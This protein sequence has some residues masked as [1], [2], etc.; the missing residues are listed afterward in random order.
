[1]VG[2]QVTTDTVVRE[3]QCGGG[4]A[5]VDFVNAV[6]SD[7]QRSSGDVGCGAGG[8]VLEGIVIGIGTRDGDTGDRDGFVGAEVFIGEAGCGV[9]VGH[10]VTRDA[11]VRES[12]SGGGGAVVD[13]VET[14]STNCER[15][16]GDVGSGAG[17]GVLE[18]VVVGVCTSNGDAGDCDSLA[19]ADVL[20]GERRGSVD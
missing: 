17:G 12:D 5:V 1:M 20:V 13:L 15:T 4:G 14:V 3:S 7:C 6:S 16:H 8:G 10:Q 9:A 11:I 2:Q 19:T 18:G